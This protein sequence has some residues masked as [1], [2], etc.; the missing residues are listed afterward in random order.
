MLTNTNTNKLK[1]KTFCYSI[2][3]KKN[4][5]EEKGNNSMKRNKG[6]YGL[7]KKNKVMNMSFEKRSYPK[8]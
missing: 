3:T 8:Y 1:L 4:N 5:K 2:K 7:Y 6:K